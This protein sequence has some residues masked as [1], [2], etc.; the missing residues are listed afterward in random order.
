MGILL[1]LDD[2]TDF[3]PDARAELV[4]LRKNAE[5]WLWLR[6]SGDATCRPLTGQWRMNPKQCDA[7]ADSAMASA[8]AVGAA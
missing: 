3:H 8:R 4:A 6:D 5:R 7:A 2:L 1:D